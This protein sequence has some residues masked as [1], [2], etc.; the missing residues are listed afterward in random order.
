MKKKEIFVWHPASRLIRWSNRTKRG[1]I[2]EIFL[3]M[4]S[5]IKRQ[6]CWQKTTFQLKGMLPWKDKIWW[7]RRSCGRYCNKALNQREGG[8]PLDLM[9][10]TLSKK[11][12]TLCLFKLVA[13]LRDVACG[14]LI[15]RSWCLRM[16]PE[17]QS[18]PAS[19]L[20]DQERGTIHF[21]WVAYW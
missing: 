11:E 2:E 13:L 17:S 12:S 16:K 18:L 9:T 4:N 20:T 7:N 1:T 21:S 3:K 14:F 19:F 5:E 8:M 6:I 15:E 10:S